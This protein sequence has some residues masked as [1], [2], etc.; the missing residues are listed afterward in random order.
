M[1]TYAYGGDLVGDRRSAEPFRRSEM[2]IQRLGPQVLMGE[3]A[4][5]TRKRWWRRLI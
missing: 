4:N 5:V 3:I 2:T 1:A